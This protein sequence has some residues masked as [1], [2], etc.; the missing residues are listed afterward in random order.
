MNRFVKGGVT[1]KM[2]HALP[3]EDNTAE[4]FVAW[5]LRKNEA[6]QPTAALQGLPLPQALTK[7]PYTA[8]GSFAKFLKTLSEICRMLW[9]LH[10]RGIVHRNLNPE[11]ILLTKNLVTLIGFLPSPSEAS[12][13]SVDAAFIG[14]PGYAPP[15]QA[16]GDQVFEPKSDVFSLGAILYEALTNQIPFNGTGME[17]KLA[18]I[19]KD[20][21]PIRKQAPACPSSLIELCDSMLSKDPDLRPNAQ[22]VQQSLLQLAQEFP[23]LHLPLFSGKKH[24]P[25]ISPTPPKPET[26]KPTTEDQLNH[27]LP[28]R[29]MPVALQP[30]DTRSPGALQPNIPKDRYFIEYEVGHGGIGKVSRA[31]DQRLQ[32]H[33]A[34]K[35]LIK[36]NFDSR[37][38]FLREALLTARLQHP[39]IVPIYDVGVRSNGEIFYSMKLISGKPLDEII[40]EKKT[41]HERLALLPHVL[42]IAEALAY[43][44]SQQV[45]HR[46]LKP[47]NILIGEFGETFVIDWGSAKDLKQLD[48]LQ[49]TPKPLTSI[50][51]LAI[52]ES[53]KTPDLTVEGTVIGTPAYMPPEQALGLAANESSD[54]YALGAILYHLLVGKPPIRDKE[55][56]MIQQVQECSFVPLQEAQPKTPDDL[57]A[58]IQKAMS[59]E[60]RDRYPSAL[61]FA[62]D[63]RK[64]QNGQLV[65]AYKYSLVQR[66]F[67]YAKKRKQAFAVGATATLLMITGGTV[68]IRSIVQE[69]RATQKSLNNLILMQ[70]RNELEHNPANSISWI[71]LLP[72]DYEGFSIARMIASDAIRRGIPIA[73]NGHQKQL[74]DISYSHNGA[75]IGSAGSDGTIHIWNTKSYQEKIFAA[76]GEAINLEFSRDD[77]LIVGSYSDGAVRV[78]DVASGALITSLKGH[79]GRVV[80][81]AFSPDTKLLASSGEDKK[82]YLWDLETQ[83]RRLI[84]QSEQLIENVKFSPDGKTLAAAIWEN[85]NTSTIN[86]Y[87]LQD[88]TLDKINLPEPTPTPKNVLPP[89]DLPP[90]PN[91]QLLT[92][93]FS[94]NGN[95]IVAAGY[96]GDLFLYNQETKILQKLSGHAG[97]VNSLSFSPDETQL[98]SGGQD[99]TV[100]IWDTKTGA[101]TKVYK[102]HV[103]GIRALTFSH[104]GQFLASAGG[105]KT[106]QLWDLPN[107]QHRILRR[108]E[109]IVSSLSFSLDDKILAS[110]G[111][112]SLLLLWEVEPSDRRLL[113]QQEELIAAVAISGD[114]SL[115]AAQKE[116]KLLIWSIQ[117]LKIKTSIDFKNKI[118]SLAFSPDQ[119]HLAVSDDKGLIHLFNIKKEP[120][121]INKPDKPDKNHRDIVQKLL[122]ID[123]T[124]L[125]S[126]SNDHSIRIW[127]LTSGAVSILDG[128]SDYVTSLAA[129]P[130]HQ[131]LSVSLDKS[132]KIWDLQKNTL[133]RSINL[134]EV[135]FDVSLSN[136]ALLVAVSTNSSAIRIWKLFDLLNNKKPNPTLLEGHN[137][138]TTKV[139]F[140]GEAHLLISGSADNTLRLWDV[141]NQESSMLVGHTGLISGL[142]VAREA[143][144]FVSSSVDGSV[145]IWWEKVPEGT[146]AFLQWLTTIPSPEVSDKNLPQ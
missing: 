85:E 132:L 118:I 21:P 108:H 56:P 110:G 37:E 129:A 11:N 95:Y 66:F 14:T 115:I 75:W 19:D 76:A 141:D 65:D 101:E 43:A 28:L 45:I 15:E 139:A 130:N 69:Q 20:P 9:S 128:H 23:Q 63:L 3:P 92:V 64:F 4:P 88:Q 12:T 131:L 29:P 83:E 97:I 93:E 44:H 24:A 54:V 53:T 123:N 68:S 2:N 10:E 87:S 145:R 46:D 52:M 109:D 71:K 30:Y 47:N 38:R 86:V 82:V 146:A 6:P 1:I 107:N 22:E 7:P 48:L 80:Y 18:T 78:W 127:N 133:L 89:E 126:A 90:S 142:S 33:V 73:L 122:F 113:F 34:I 116:E 5:E 91:L 74:Q 70:A 94:P 16:R 134:G 98:A 77:T 112:D 137:D 143:N 119:S 50:E 140:V 13:S 25:I 136:D 36:D 39:A 111:Y 117:E 79:Q 59:K 41:F 99:K 62:E 31:H 138:Q 35:E 27:L 51:L 144:I 105:D 49:P 114:G 42:L 96:A 81:C 72:R 26:N 104:N 135:G 67:K 84:F 125:A 124:T 103:G 102:G 61:S 8:A 120:E 57:L 100:R 60:Q 40:Q 58:I 106:V 121:K 32:R 55:K 17:L